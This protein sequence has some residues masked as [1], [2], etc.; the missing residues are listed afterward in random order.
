MT[1]YLDDFIRPLV[2]ILPN[3]SG[4]VKHITDED[5]DK[6]KNK[7]NKLVSSRIGDDKVLEKY[8]TI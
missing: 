3:M 6:D 5:G 1:R 2:S 7:N 8:K 4:D